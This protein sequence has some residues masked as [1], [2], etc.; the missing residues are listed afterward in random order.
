MRK[1][2]NQSIKAEESALSNS[3]VLGQFEGECADATITNKNGL[4]ITQEV[5]ETVFNSEDYKQAIDLKWYIGFLGHPEDPNCMDFEHACIVMK[6]GHIDPD[7]KVY[8]TFDL[9]DTPVGRIVKS[10]IDAGVTFGISVRGAGDIIDNSVDPD[11]FVF[12]GFDLVTFPAYP[13]AIPTFTEIAASSDIDKQQKYKAVC[14]A[15]KKNIDGI[16]TVEAATILQS[17]FAK[18]SEE[19]KMLEKK[20]AEIT[21]SE[22]VDISQNKIDGLTDLYLS[23]ATELK[24]ANKK[25]AILESQIKAM[26]QRYVRKIKSVER[27]MASQMADIEATSG[28]YVKANLTLKSANSHMKNEVQSLKASNDALKDSNLKYKQKIEATT[29]EM[30]QKESVISELRSDLSETVRAASEAEAKTSNRDDTIKDLRKQ[31]SASVQ[32]VQEYQDAFA[33]LYATAL[34]VRVEDIKITASTS[35][36]ELKSIIGSACTSQKSAIMEP[37][38]VEEIFESNEYDDDTLVTM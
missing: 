36:D 14:A 30:K 12:R 2:S 19:Y 20:I 13:E 22:T 15:V 11:T 33:N 29:A 25:V 37:T 35:V 3:T 27:I 23:A 6:E 10:F 7:G 1:K 21:A 4:D 18:Q 38:H 34:G 26:E 31:I 8:G 17:Q 5:W 32:L 16:N 28:E 9:V 24:A